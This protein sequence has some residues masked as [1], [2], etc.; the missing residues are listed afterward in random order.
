LLNIYWS[1]ILLLICLLPFDRQS[2]LDPNLKNTLILT[3]FLILVFFIGF[4]YESVD[5]YGY[6][7]IFDSMSFEN[8]NFPQFKNKINNISI[9][10]IFGFLISIFKKLN[11]SFYSFIFIFSLTSLSIKF[12]FINKYSPYFF[13]SSLLFFAFLIGKDMG[14]IRNAMISGIILFAII[15]LI[16]RNLLSY[17]LIV[18]IASGIQIFAL[19]AL[20]IYWIYPYL[21]KKNIITYALIFSLLIFVVGGIFHYLAHFSYLFGNYIDAK[22]TIYITTKGSIPINL[23]TLSFIFFAILFN[24]VKEKYI[25]KES[26]EEGLFIYYIYAVIVFLICSDLS[27]ISS[28]VMDYLGSMTLIIL[29][30][31]LIHKIKSSQIKIIAYSLIVCFSIIRFIPMVRTMEEYKNIFIN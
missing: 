1:W 10:F 12:F 29:I 25:T 2:N 22:I 17:L 8:I 14:Q 15:P 5:Y 23:N 20:P 30:P 4:R 11:L 27:I 21:K 18:L 6:K 9:E 28:R 19:I 26:F 16:K 13:L 31:Y 7:N 24:F 3:F